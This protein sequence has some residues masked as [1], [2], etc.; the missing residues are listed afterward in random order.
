MK[1]IVRI[2]TTSLIAIFLSVGCANQQPEDIN[3]SELET[4]CK[5]V[6]AIE[7]CLNSL[8]KMEDKYGKDVDE[9]ELSS[10]DRARTVVIQEIMTEIIQDLPKKFDKADVMKCSNFEKV[11]EASKKYF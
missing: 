7:T 6:D 3:L 1:N 5:Y 9:D 8:A 10:E 2:Y 11:E 4:A